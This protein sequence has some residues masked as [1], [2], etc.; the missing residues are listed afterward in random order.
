MM[1]C[2]Q[3]NELWKEIHMMPEETAQAGLDIRA[4]KIMPIHWGS[5]KLAMHPWTEPVERVSDK[6][7]TLGLPVVVPKI[8][9]PIY[10]EETSGYQDKWWENFN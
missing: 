8:G 9:E 6:A 2:G 7:A 5:F 10:L 4:T 3:Y 1:E